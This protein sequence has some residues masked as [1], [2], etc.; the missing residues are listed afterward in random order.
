MSIAHGMMFG[1]V[2]SLRKT[3][4][5]LETLEEIELLDLHMYRIYCSIYALCRSHNHSLP[6]CSH[7]HFKAQIKM[8]MYI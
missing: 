5:L 4:S 8:L 3:S 6:A 7:D 1:P 2:D